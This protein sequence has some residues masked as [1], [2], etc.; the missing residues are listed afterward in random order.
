MMSTGAVHVNVHE[1]NGR[2]GEATLAHGLGFDVGPV[3]APIVVFVPKR[4]GVEGVTLVIGAPVLF[5]TVITIV[6]VSPGK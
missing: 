6:A 3:Y 2:R 4:A 1:D 5:V